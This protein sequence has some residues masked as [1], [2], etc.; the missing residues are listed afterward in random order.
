M[1]LGKERIILGT[2][3]VVVFAVFVACI[4]S[5][6]SMPNW[7]TA[8]LSSLFFALFP[9]AGYIAILEANAA[10]IVNAKR[11]L[12]TWA[13]GSAS[14]L[15]WGA[16]WITHDAQ[17]N[18]E[19]RGERVPYYVLGIVVVY[20]GISVAFWMATT[21]PKTGG[22][23]PATPWQQVHTTQ[24]VRGVHAPKSKAPKSKKKDPKPDQKLATDSAR[25]K[26]IKENLKR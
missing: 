2:V 18:I 9:T 22:K 1:G 14:V 20:I 4:M 16:V 8:L 19:M 10:H 6:I 26:R 25:W 17:S 15:L 12:A 7:A 11:S 5:L 23:R 24:G 13:F 21:F 3:E